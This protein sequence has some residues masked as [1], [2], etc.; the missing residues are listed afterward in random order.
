[1]SWK[2]NGFSYLLWFIYTMAVSVGMLGFFGISM[3]FLDAWGEY[4]FLAIACVYLLIGILVFGLH[5]LIV[6]KN[7]P[8]EGASIVPVVVE[9]VLV[10]ALFVAGIVLRM[11]IMPY[12]TG[13]GADMVYFEAAKVVEGKELPL[14][15]HGAGYIYLKVLH[16]VFLL[17]G[18]RF[19]AAVW[20]QVV[21]YVVAC[22]FLYFVVRELAGKLPAIIMLVFMMISPFNLLHTMELSPEILYL[23]IYS[24]ALWAIAGSLKKNACNP[25][26][27]IAVGVLIGVSCYL[28]ITGLS[29]LVFAAGVLTVEREQPVKRWNIRAWALGLNVVGAILGWLVIIILDALLCGKEILSVMFAWLQLYWPESFTLWWEYLKAFDG[30]VTNGAILY[31]FLVF[32][33]FSFWCR[34]KQERQGIWT[35]AVL[36]L[37]LLNCFQ[38]VTSEVPGNTCLYAFLTVLAG[39]SLADIFAVAPVSVVAEEQQETEAAYAAEDEFEVL[40]EEPLEIIDVEPVKTQIKFLDNPLPL[41]KKHEAK[42]MDYQ[43]TEIAE[44]DFDY[45]VADGDDFDI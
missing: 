41:P 13:E 20:L 33:V 12:L 44:A 37:I 30:F 32:G 17:F 25:F 16:A 14:V 34:R 26:V 6:K 5:R 21:L 29:L 22:I 27:Y 1:M 19:I 40:E 9:G 2:K 4:C 38:M 24:I 36:V 23:L 42:V 15:V 35:G 7:P 43:I 10:L 8:K 11:N 45:D 18:N 3:G 31:V 39:V 28:D